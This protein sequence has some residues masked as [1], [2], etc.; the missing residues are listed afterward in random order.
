[1]GEILYFDLRSDFGIIAG[2]EVQ[3]TTSSVADDFHNLKF[4]IHGRER[5]RETGFLKPAKLSEN[6]T[7]TKLI[8]TAPY[9]PRN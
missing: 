8:G 4:T 6:S 5:E 9:E 2:R 1:L 7:H 3:T